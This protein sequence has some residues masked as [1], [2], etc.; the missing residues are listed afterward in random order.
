MKNKYFILIIS[1]FL[2]SYPL[3]VFAKPEK[4]VVAVFDFDILTNSIAISEGTQLA[5][6]FIGHLANCD[7]FSIV[8]RNKV[9]KIIK[10]QGFQTSGYV[11]VK[12]AVKIGN[13]LGAKQV[14][15]GSVIEDA[16]YIKLIVK[17]VNAQTGEIINTDIA[18]SNSKNDLSKMIKEIAT[19]YK[20]GN[21]RGEILISDRPN[22]YLAA[23]MSFALPGSG[24]FYMG[25]NTKGAIYAL[26]A[27]AGLTSLIIGMTN[28]D[29]LTTN[30]G[31]GIMI[32]IGIWAP[33]DILFFERDK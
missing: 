7:N 20:T 18:K 19:D 16:N 12:S 23:G 22:P 31:S 11:D 21:L 2:I 8:E 17:L 13:L 26:I 32:G 9:Y 24:Q 5:E 15:M 33:I 6:E 3:N 4:T 29:D 1:L 25:E 30:I 27:A 14:F 28:K 10:E